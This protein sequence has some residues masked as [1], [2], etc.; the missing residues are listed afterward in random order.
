MSR[1]NQQKVYPSNAYHFQNHSFSSIQSGQGAIFKQVNKQQQQ[2]Q[3]FVP[4]Y[5][6]SNQYTRKAQFNNLFDVYETEIARLEN[7]V[8]QLVH[9]INTL[10]QNG[11]QEL[12][13]FDQKL[14][15][16]AK[17]NEKL[18]QENQDILRMNEQLLSENKRLKFLLEEKKNTPIVK[19]KQEKIFY[20]FDS[21]MEEDES[22]L[23]KA[24]TGLDQLKDLISNLNSNLKNETENNFSKEKN[25]ELS[26]REV[27]PP[28][29]LNKTDSKISSPIV[30]TTYQ[31]TKSYNGVLCKRSAEKKKMCVKKKSVYRKLFN[32]K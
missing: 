4:D 31:V 22:R 25:L 26:N 1:K 19:I 21:Q 18:F 17:L 28:T 14:L 32:L 8:F 6:E 20:D 30:E 12:A 27:A 10:H 24:S 13:N 3:K 2:P 7:H 29:N 11:C 15:M 9:E 5:A 16:H 23:E